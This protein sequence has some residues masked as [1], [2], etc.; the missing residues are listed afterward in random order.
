MFQNPAPLVWKVA[1]ISAKKG[2]IRN[3]ML[4]LES[5]HLPWKNGDARE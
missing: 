3:R 1:S 2:V 4:Q 5:E